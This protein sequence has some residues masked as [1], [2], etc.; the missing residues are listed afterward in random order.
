[1][2]VAKIWSWGSWDP[3]SCTKNIKDKTCTHCALG[4]KLNSLHNIIHMTPIKNS[5]YAHE[6]KHS[7]RVHIIN[8]HHCWAKF[9]CR[10]DAVG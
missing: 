10:I 6:I 9:G 1:M 4:I 5:G 7:P 2:G 8:D 3:Q